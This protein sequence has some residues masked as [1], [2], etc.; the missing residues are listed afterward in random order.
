ME[1]SSM[2]RGVVKGMREDYDD[3]AMVSVEIELPAKKTKKAPGDGPKLATNYKPTRNV[4][5]SQEMAA[6]LSM[7]QP[8]ECITTIRPFGKYTPKA[9]A[10]EEKAEGEKS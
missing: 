5:V 8:V 6:S 7:G 10:A 9:A 1:H 4:T 3:K 2:Y